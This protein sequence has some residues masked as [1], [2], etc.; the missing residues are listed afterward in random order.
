MLFLYIFASSIKF[1]MT[2]VNAQLPSNY[3][4]TLIAIKERINQARYQSLKAVNKELILAYLEIGKM[5]S[6]RAATG[7][8]DAVVDKLSSDLQIE[9]PGVSGFSKRNPWR[10][11]QIHEQFNENSI[12]P[13]LVAKLPLPSN[14]AQYLPNE[15]ELLE[16]INDSRI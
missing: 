1:K 7:W 12:W 4:Q 8:G 15:S 9:F 14:I 2:H 11:R 13:Q 6:E 16:M 5:I 3:A 10:M